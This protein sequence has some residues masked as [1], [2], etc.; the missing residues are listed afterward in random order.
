ML[1]AVVAMANSN[2]IGGNNNLLWNIPRDLKRFKNLTEGHIV[3]MGRK[4]FE[5]LPKILP[6]RF[7]IVLTENHQYEIYNPRVKVIN[8]IEKIKTLIEGEDEVFVIGGGEIFRLFMPWIDKIY[9]TRIY[10]DFK[11]D[12]F[13]PIIDYSQWKVI[14]EERIDDFK[15]K[16][17]FIDMIRIKEN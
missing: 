1:S 5:A 7:H 13:F 15:Y 8:S 10:E 9:L 12:T 3:I 14:Y 4:T 11:G 16:Y 2:V 17:D 6:N